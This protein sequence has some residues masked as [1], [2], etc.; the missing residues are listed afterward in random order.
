MHG[1]AGQTVGEDLFDAAAV[2]HDFDGALDGVRHFRAAGFHQ[3][4]LEA[5]PASFDAEFNRGDLVGLQIERTRISVRIGQVKP[6]FAL[7]LQL[8]GLRSLKVVIDGYG[9]G[10]LVVLR[11][12]D[13]QIEIDE[14]VLE[15]AQRRRHPAKQAVA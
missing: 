9:K 4:R 12:A 8:Y 15:N 5:D 1:L 7:Q 13:R 10:N 11:Q 6:R 2:G 3:K 14:E